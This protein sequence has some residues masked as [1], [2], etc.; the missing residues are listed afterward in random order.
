MEYYLD[1]E[2][3]GLNPETDKIVTLQYQQLNS[4]GDPVGNLVI[5]KEW[6][7]GEEELIKRFLTVFRKW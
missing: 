5:L 6:E 3:Q 1:L 4:E 2:T 7:L